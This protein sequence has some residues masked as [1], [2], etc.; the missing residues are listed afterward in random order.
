MNQA[1][2]SQLAVTSTKPRFN[3][4]IDDPSTCSHIKEKIASK[5]S[6]C[7]EMVC[8]TAFPTYHQPLIL[9]HPEAYCKKR[10]VRWRPRLPKDCQS[11]TLILDS[12]K[13]W[14]ITCCP[15]EI[16]S[17]YSPTS[18]SMKWKVAAPQ[19]ETMELKS[20]KEQRVAWLSQCM[21]YWLRLA[22]ADYSCWLMLTW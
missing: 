8:N 18:I 6:S 2:T 11:L 12:N 3:G 20:S 22:R 10:V 17:G 7:W 13:S 9:L 15:H 21:K 4:F 19:Q 14:W 16:A 1:S 5:H